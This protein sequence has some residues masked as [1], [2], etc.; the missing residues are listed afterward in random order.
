MSKKDQVLMRIPGPT[1]HMMMM[2]ITCG[3]RR[4]MRGTRMK[5]QLW[6]MKIWRKC[7]GHDDVRSVAYS[8]L[9][10]A[11]A[12]LLFS[13]S[14]TSDPF[15]T[16]HYLRLLISVPCYFCYTQPSITDIET[17]VDDEQ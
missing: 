7:M 9:E 16:S 17:S 12:R 5:D 11:E 15:V 10:E 8:P 3:M 1:P 4:K 2:K 6:G 13:V 14:L